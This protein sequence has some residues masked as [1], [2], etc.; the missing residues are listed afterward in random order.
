MTSREKDLLHGI[1]RFVNITQTLN[2]NREFV[3]GKSM[4]RNDVINKESFR[5]FHWKSLKCALAIL[6]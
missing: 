6:L 2:D 5:R 4:K 3:A 1:R